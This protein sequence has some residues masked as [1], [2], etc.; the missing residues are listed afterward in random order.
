MSARKTSRMKTEKRADESGRGA[1]ARLDAAMAARSLARSC[2]AA[3]QRLHDATPATD[4]YEERDSQAIQC[5]LDGTGF[6]SAGVAR[7]SDDAHSVSITAQ[8]SVGAL[9]E[10]M[11]LEVRDVASAQTVLT[12]AAVN[13]PQDA[14]E[15]SVG[16]AMVRGLGM[17]S[18]FAEPIGDDDG[19]VVGYLFVADLK[20]VTF[21][22]LVL[23]TFQ[24]NVGTW[25]LG[26]GAADG[27]SG[28]M[29]ADGT[30]S[31]RSDLLTDTLQ[32]MGLGIIVVDTALTVTAVNRQTHEMLDVPQD[33]LYV[34]ALMHDLINY[35]GERGD[36][37][38]E[39]AQEQIEKMRQIV[40]NR[41]PHSFERRLP[42]GCVISCKFQPRADGCVFTYT[43]VTEFYDRER[44]R[45]EHEE[46]LSDTLDHMEQGLIV[47]DADMEILA[48][49]KQTN[50]MLDVPRDILR[51][52]SN[53]GAFVSYC[54]QRGDYG[55]EDPLGQLV[56]AKVKQ[57]KAYMIERQFANGRTVVCAAQPRSGGGY[58]A[59]YMDVTQ[60]RQSEQELDTK[61]EL[62][63]VALDYM[64]QGLI[65]YDANLMIEAFNDRA[66]TLLGVPEHALQAGASMLILL[67]IWIKL[68][69]GDGDLVAEEVAAFREIV[70][71]GEAFDHELAVAGGGTI[72]CSGRPRDN[73]GYVL[74]LSDV[75]ESKRQKR[76]LADK[77][78]MMEAIVQ[79]MD[80][81]LLAFDG[82][83]RLLF[84][85]ERAKMMLGAPRE[86]F[87]PGQNF[88][89]VV[90]QGIEGGGSSIDQ[91]LARMH[92]AE[93]FSVERKCTGNT[94]ALV[95]FHPRPEGGYIA[96]YT[97]ITATRRQQDELS[98]MAEE[99]RLKGVQLDTVFTNM[100]SG[101]AMFDA[102]AKLVICNPRYQE[103]FQ[104]TDELIQ[105]GVSLAAQ[106]KYCIEQGFEAEGENLVS[107]RTAVAKSREPTS[108]NIHMVDGRTIN[109]VHEPL[110]GGGSIAVYDDV[111]ERVTAERKLRDYADDLERQKSILQTVMEHMDQGIS[112]ADGDLN[113]QAFNSRFLELL[114]F[115]ADRFKPGDAMAKFFLHNAQRGEYGPGDEDEQVRERVELAAKFEAH[116][117][118]RERPDGT[119]IKIEGK[120]L[121]DGEGFVTTY[122]DITEARGNEIEIQALAQRLTETNLRLDAAF[123][124]MNQGLA[125]FDKEHRLVVRNKS[126]LDIFQFPEELA[127]EGAS[128]ED[129]TR[130]SVA[131]GFEADTSDQ[132]V[133]QRMEIAAMRERAMYHRNMADGRIV[134]IIHEPLENGG[135]L[136]LYLDVTKRETAERML[137][138]HASKLE[139]SNRELQ[140]FAYVAAHDL[141][142][143][144][145]KIEAFGDRLHKKCGDAL[146]ED[147]QRYVTRMQASSR[148]LR[149]LIDA[150]L[151]YSRVTTKAAPFKEIDLQRL[152]L[153]VVSDLELSIEKADAV[154]E[155]SALPKVT[156][157]ETQLRQLFMN[158]IS[159]ALKFRHRDRQL[160][161]TIGA[162]IVVPDQGDEAGTE[163]C[164]LSFTDNGIGFDPKYAD[165]IF[166]IFQRLHSRAE[167]EGTG[168]GLA[169]CRKIAERHRGSIECMGTPG[170]GAE[171][172][173]T[174]PV[175]QEMLVAHDADPT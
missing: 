106:G 31:E 57:G 104:L 54:A 23:R 131:S 13:I 169:T 158:L 75:T 143:P 40:A 132:A 126:Y 130:F 157:D 102:D 20:P 68:A 87:E 150:L 86:L 99:L 165:R 4:Q 156:G 129:I 118:V 37:G 5:L 49:N 127:C 51:V 14:N 43:D 39:A 9:Q 81:G 167:Y 41:E 73:G 44:E 159:N 108:A 82:Q 140:E 55:A 29:D 89:N 33:R 72:S 59:T 125:M 168:I 110:D 3:L 78:S 175:Q 84:A 79:H 74:T 101:V 135:S 45:L 111:T 117:F 114:E 107:E 160:K 48:V 52:G 161:L 32:N 153:T 50:V 163:M 21:G 121:T 71:G 8:S 34:G 152:A 46:L 83:L 173:V 62:L 19:S 38:P 109:V 137:R 90:R 138:E 1:G 85:N 26:D 141:Q 162:Q 30:G 122:T 10:T 65:V 88:E 93:P 96:T 7:F 63:S 151:D 100:G 97:D 36:Y 67:E 170:K 42:N 16:D 6:T 98:G 164:V 60:W 119:L 80:Q 11:V 94:T 28:G 53:M 128:L 142:E 15:N 145:R 166:T 69:I 154:V 17:A 155:L 25:L 171:F 124:N 172:Q 58:I 146:G 27:A 18:F 149:S 139:A 147:G 134:E 115:P 56:M 144:L 64:D 103:I 105:P 133:C 61:S 123:N 2:E 148:R 47:F 113:V 92:G 66:R 35:F 76:E 12:G 120:P 112:L 22:G 77:T 91:M 136:A 24:S 116:C 70:S 95:R 174:L